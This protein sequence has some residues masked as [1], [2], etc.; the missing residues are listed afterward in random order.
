MHSEQNIEGLLEAA[1]AIINKYQAKAKLEKNQ[2]NIFTVLR[3]E[4]EE[5]CLHSRFIFE[6]LNQRSKHE[7]GNIF[8]MIISLEVK[9]S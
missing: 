6:L 4:S 8:L 2:F 3:D 5:V 1:K 9:I 7:M